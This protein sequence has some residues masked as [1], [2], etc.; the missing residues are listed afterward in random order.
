MTEFINDE[1]L[2]DYDRGFLH[3]LQTYAINKDGQQ[4]V[5]SCGTTLRYA[6]EHYRQ[7]WNY[8][9]PR[10]QAE[11]L[12]A[13]IDYHHAIDILFAMLIDRSGKN[14]EPLFL[15]SRSAAWQACTDGHQAILK[16]GG[17]L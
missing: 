11:L 7:A 4:W 9:P 16:A 17:K 12:K 13:C 15:P 6:S 1:K 2:S 3:G 8:L 10:R 5:G 14:G